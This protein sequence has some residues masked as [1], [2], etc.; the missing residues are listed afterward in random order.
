[1]LPVSKLL[2]L[3]MLSSLLEEQGPCIQDC[4]GLNRNIGK[5]SEM[6]A[7][8][9]EIMVPQNALMPVVKPPAQPSP[10]SSPTSPILCK[11]KKKKNQTILN[12]LNMTGLL[13][14]PCL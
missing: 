14:S 11:K 1:M 10:Y 2:V 3:F 9:Q 12:S 7:Q 6:S 8:S 13:T 5:G 4:D